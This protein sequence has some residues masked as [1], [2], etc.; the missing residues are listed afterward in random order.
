MPPQ[1]IDDLRVE[2]LAAVIGIGSNQCCRRH[3]EDA[4]VGA[5]AIEAVD[6]GHWQFSAVD[7]P[8]GCRVDAGSTSQP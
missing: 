4:F 2:V 1:S 6:E 3:L 5:R 8:C 7:Q